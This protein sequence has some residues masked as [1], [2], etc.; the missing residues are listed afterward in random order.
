MIDD[1][2]LGL[3]PPR[4]DHPTFEDHHH[5]CAVTLLPL[6]IEDSRRRL[7]VTT[8]TTILEELYRLQGRAI[9]EE[10]RGA[11]IIDDINNN[12]SV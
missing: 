11:V 5:L 9:I 4:L 7:T 3:T 6:S 8:T 1:Q 2:G 12:M 10:V